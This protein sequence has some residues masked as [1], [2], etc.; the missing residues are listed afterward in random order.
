MFGKI[1]KIDNNEVIVENISK[2]ALSSLMNC[3]LVF[4]DNERKVV[5]EVVYIDEQIVRISWG[6]RKHHSDRD[7]SV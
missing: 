5:G 3:H 2:K 4:E 1:L 7:Q 6:K